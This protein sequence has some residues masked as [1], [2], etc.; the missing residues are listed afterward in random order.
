VPGDYA[1]SLDVTETSER[2]GHIEETISRHPTG[3]AIGTNMTTPGRAAMFPFARHGGFR[4]R[5][6]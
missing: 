3:T 6:R 5:G 2:F 4:Y 1:A